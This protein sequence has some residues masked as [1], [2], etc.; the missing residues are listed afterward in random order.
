VEKMCAVY[1]V[2]RSGYYKWEARSEISRNL[3]SR[4]RSELLEKIRGIFEN[5]AAV[6]VR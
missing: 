2:S 1:Q 6:T 4:K 5:T 3:R